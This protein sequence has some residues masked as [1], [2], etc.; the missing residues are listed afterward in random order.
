MDVE[1][2]K[3]VHT[4]EFLET[5]E[6]HLTGTSDK[7]EQFGTLFFVKRTHRPPEPLDLLRRGRIVVVFGVVLP[8]ININ[9]RQAR[10]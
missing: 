5:I 3:P 10:N 9:F 7:L 4:L 2:T 1:F 6:R 8:I